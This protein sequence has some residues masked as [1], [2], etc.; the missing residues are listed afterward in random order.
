MTTEDSVL[1]IQQ[2]AETTGLSVH[3]LRY[4][5]RIGLI[6]PI[7]RAENTH[8]RYRTQDLSW[9]EFLNKLRCARMSIQQMNAYAELQRQGDETLPERLEML[10]AH[11]L[12]VQAH[13]DELCEHLNL[14]DHKIEVYK[15]IVSTKSPQ[16]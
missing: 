13:M 11:R 7:E 12:K 4:Y 5:E 2:A 1:T 9:I 15:E 8:R 14:I 3:T 10:K 6:D 16:K